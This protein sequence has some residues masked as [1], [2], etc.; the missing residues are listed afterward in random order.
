MFRPSPNS[1]YAGSPDPPFFLVYRLPLAVTKNT[2]FQ[3]FFGKSSRDYT[4]RPPPP[5]KYAAPLCMWVR[6]GRS[7]V[8]LITL[9]GRLPFPDSVGGIF[10]GPATTQ[11]VDQGIEWF[12]QLAG[13]QWLY[14]FEHVD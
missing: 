3:G 1:T 14:S 6:K 12:S 13:L 9:D 4:F 10:P 2:P 11:K 8:A 5:P 7:G